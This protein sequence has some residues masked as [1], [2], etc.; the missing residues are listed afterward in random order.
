MPT[1]IILHYIILVAVAALVLGPVFYRERPSWWAL[2]GFSFPVLI[3]ATEMLTGALAA[4]ANAG[5]GWQLPL[6]MSVETIPFAW[7]GSV[8][9]WVG[10]TVGARLSRAKDQYY[11]LPA[12]AG[13]LLVGL[14]FFA[15][16][17]DALFL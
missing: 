2:A 8:I 17:F 1:T 3:A 11:T 13:S 12:I 9:L 4:A 7:W 10:C 6:P 16:L 5:L 14:E 15:W